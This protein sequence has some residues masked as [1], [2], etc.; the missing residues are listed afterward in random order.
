[1]VKGEKDIN[2]ARFY[3]EKPKN[4]RVKLKFINPFYFYEKSSKSSYSKKIL[5]RVN[6]CFLLT[7]F[8]NLIFERI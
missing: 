5:V 7:F 4:S 6:F 2:S 8:P 1:M 3:D